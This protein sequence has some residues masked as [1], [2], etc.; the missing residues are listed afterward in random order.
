MV[1]G[2]VAIVGCVFAFFMSQPLIPQEPAPPRLYDLV[3]GGV[4]FI[5]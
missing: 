4:D 2:S 5:S 1:I 3:T